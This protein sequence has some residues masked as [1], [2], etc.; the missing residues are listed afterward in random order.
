MHL[1]HDGHPPSEALTSRPPTVHSSR[2]QHT[3]HNTYY[4]LLTHG[5]YAPRITS[6]MHLQLVS[7]R[8][9]IIENHLMTHASQNHFSL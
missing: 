8:L 6:L 5:T 1:A 7:I 9:R 2:I 3:I 4:I